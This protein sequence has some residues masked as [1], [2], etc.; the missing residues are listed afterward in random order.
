MKGGDGTVSLEPAGQLELSGA[1]LENLHDTCAETG[2]HLAGQGNRRALRRRLPWPG[3]VARQDPRRI[4]GHAQGALRHHDAAHAQ[5]GQ[6]GPRHDAAHLHHPGQSRLFERGRH[7]A[8]VPHRAGLQPLATAL[9]ANALHR[10]E[11]PTVTCPIAAI[12]GAI[13]IRIAPVCCPSCSKTASDT[14]A[15]S[16]TCSTPMYFVFRD[17]KYLD[18]AGG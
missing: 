15:G 11:N 3:H 7:G 4:A 1:P 17:G 2:R 6:S 18:A 14:N 8:E 16:T 12:S 5:S 10:R 13:P 9:F